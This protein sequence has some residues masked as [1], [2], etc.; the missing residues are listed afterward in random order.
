MPR[1]SPGTGPR[2]SGTRHR[3]QTGSTIE[4]LR[5]SPAGLELVD[6]TS[7]V[8]HAVESRATTHALA[9]GMLL[10]F[11]AGWHGETQTASGMGIS[12]FTEDGRHLWSTLDAEPAWIVETAGG[13]GYV[14][15]PELAYPSGTRVIDLATGK[16]LRTVKR[17]LPT[18]VTRD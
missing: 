4:N 7:G 12:A 1:R 16:V 8:R 5:Q 6:P 3:S 13:Y 15:T 14:P 9:S 17:E 10:A 18:F 11:G 2:T